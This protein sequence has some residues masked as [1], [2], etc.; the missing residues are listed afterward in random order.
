MGIEFDKDNCLDFMIYSL[1]SI[2]L[3]AGIIFDKIF[4]IILWFVLGFYMCFKKNEQKEKT[5]E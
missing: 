3:I 2:F 4:Y 1:I 5:N